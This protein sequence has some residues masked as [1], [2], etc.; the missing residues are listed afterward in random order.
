MNRDF[1]QHPVSP[2]E[3]AAW[4]TPAV[5]YVKRVETDGE[6]GWSI[7]AADGT[8]VGLASSRDVAFAAFQHDLEP[9]SVH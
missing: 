8:P 4:G 6:V 7:H 2:A 9:V 3:F 1:A 5:A